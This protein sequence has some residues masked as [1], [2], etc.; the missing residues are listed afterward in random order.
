MIKLNEYEKR[1]FWKATY[2]AVGGLMNSDSDTAKIWADRAIK[3]LEEAMEMP[4][5][6]GSCT[7]IALNSAAPYNPAW[8]LPRY[9]SRIK[10]RN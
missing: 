7:P 5:E 8:D 9:P 2:L 6:D 4:S 3:H 10:G 1:E